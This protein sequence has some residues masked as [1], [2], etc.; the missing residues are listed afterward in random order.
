MT[1]AAAQ[2]ALDRLRQLIE[3]DDPFLQEALIEAVEHPALAVRIFAALAL[4]E[5]FQDVHAVPALAEALDAGSR[6]QQSDSAAALWD[7]GDA[8]PAGLLRALHH[9]P[10]AARDAIAGVLQRLG[11]APDD[12]DTAVA[13]YITT[14]QWRECILLGAD[15]VPGLLSALQDWDGVVRRGAAWALGE[16]GDPRA[17]PGLAALLADQQG[18]LFGVGQRVCDIAA[19]ALLKIGTPESRRVVELWLANGP[20][21]PA[22]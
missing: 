22:A 7:L 1:L 21:G 19:E 16:I 11:W 3:E 15:G 18:G 13:Y 4:A 10:S 5:H 6:Q 20:G 12:P 17:V 8:D 2:P 14:L 9:A